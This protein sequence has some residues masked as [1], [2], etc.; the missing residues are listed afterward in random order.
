MRFLR[1]AG[2]RK[3]AL[4]RHLTAA[5][6]KAHE[7]HAEA[8]AATVPRKPAAPAPPA[9][10]PEPVVDEASQK[11]FADAHA[12]LASHLATELALQGATASPERTVRLLRKA[13]VKLAERWSGRRRHPDDAYVVAAEL[14]QEVRRLVTATPRYLEDPQ[15]QRVAEALVAVIR[16]LDGGA[17]GS[18]ACD[19]IEGFVLGVQDV[20][21]ARA[22]SRKFANDHGPMAR[23]FGAVTSP[24]HRKPPLPT[25]NTG[26]HSLVP[27]EA[28][29]ESGEVPSTFLERARERQQRSRR[30]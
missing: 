6:E 3:Q 22:G 7:T 11:V 29:G 9:S 25:G 5:R 2:D 1:E 14:G 30:G 28:A 26:E 18:W 12:L 19:T 17:D 23:A 15:T 27:H 8:R 13:G 20:S 10:P 24:K 4:E 21:Q 16:V